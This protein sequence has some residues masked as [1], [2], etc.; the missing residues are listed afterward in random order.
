MLARSC[1]YIDNYPVA[2]S[3]KFLKSVFFEKNKPSKF[4]IPMMIPFVK[5]KRTPQTLRYLVF[6]HLRFTVFTVVTDPAPKN[7]TTD[8]KKE[9][10]AE[11]VAI[12]H[13]KVTP[14]RYESII[15]AS[16]NQRKKGELSCTNDSTVG[17]AST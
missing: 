9:K 5:G 11:K 15:P 1:S 12:S 3:N 13:I 8:E 2:L 10:M 16:S 4:A 14:M 7:V 17:T 6:N